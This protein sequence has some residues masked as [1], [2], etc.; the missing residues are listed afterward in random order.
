MSLFYLF[1]LVVV[2]GTAAVLAYEYQQEVSV[3]LFNEGYTTSVPGLGFPP[4]A[5]A[6]QR[7]NRPRRLRSVAGRRDRQV[8]PEW[9]RKSPVFHPAP[10]VAAVPRGV[11]IP[12]WSPTRNDSSRGSRPESPHVYGHDEPTNSVRGFG[13]RKRRSLTTDRT[14]PSNGVPVVF[15]AESDAGVA[16]LITCGRATGQSRHPRHTPTPSGGRVHS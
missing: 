16:R 12:R 5:V 13:D 11:P 2:T 1:L 7:D 8:V 9:H 10:F 14:T 6:S 15:L 4:V 3:T